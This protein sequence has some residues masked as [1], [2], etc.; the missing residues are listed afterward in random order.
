MVYGKDGTFDAENLID[1][2]QAL[3]KFTAV[4]DEGDGTAFKVDGVRGTKVVGAAG[5]FAGSQKVDVTDRDTDAGGGRFRVSSSTNGSS[6]IS[7]VASTTTLTM[8]RD[9]VSA[10]LTP[11]NDERTVREALRFFFGKDGEVF[12]EFILEE[13]VT[14]VDASGREGLRE[15]ARS[16]GFGRI[17]PV[18]SF[19]R[20]LTPELTEN[21]RRMVRQIQT[22]VQFLLGDF[23]GGA[24]ATSLRLRKLVPVVREFAPEL[25][26]FGTLLVARL[27]EKALS[28][29]LNWAT[30]RL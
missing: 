6:M 18:P 24:A 13:V 10:A 21:D 9:G 3:E 22:L 5:D 29:G 1:L 4:R 14:V 30:A 11:T 25:R 26:N 8:S 15:L 12:R 20:A 17:V 16:L 7:S 19:V 2:L 23:D 27:T 28:R